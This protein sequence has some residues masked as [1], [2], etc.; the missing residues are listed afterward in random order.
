MTPLEHAAITLAATTPHPDI[1]ENRARAELG[2]SGT[3]LAQLTNALIDRPDVEAAL[4]REVHRLQR[5]RDLRRRAR[6]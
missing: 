1:R 3:R 2:M 5:L 6:R 4:P